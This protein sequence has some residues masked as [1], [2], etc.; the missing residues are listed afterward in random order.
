MGP[1][2][3]KNAPFFFLSLDIPDIKLF[4]S[5]DETNNIVPNIPLFDVLNKFDGKTV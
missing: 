3:K 4:Q 1:C 2:V 5:E